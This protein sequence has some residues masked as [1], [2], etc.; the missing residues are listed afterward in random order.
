MEQFKNYLCNKFETQDIV[1]QNL[2]IFR[3][4]TKE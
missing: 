1:A 4:V 2:N 3:N